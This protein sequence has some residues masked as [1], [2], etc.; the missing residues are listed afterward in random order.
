MLMYT[1]NLA[2]N[3]LLLMLNEKGRVKSYIN[4][5]GVIWLSYPTQAASDCEPNITAW[6][7]DH[8]SSGGMFRY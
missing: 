3:T 5:Y 4:R 8:I 7:M 2:L 6:K 1:I